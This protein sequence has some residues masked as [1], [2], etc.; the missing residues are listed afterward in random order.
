MDSPDDDN[1]AALA[2][3][4][5]QYT[6]A[7]MEDHR[8][9][10]RQ[11]RAI[12]ATLAIWSDGIRDWVNDGPPRDPLHT[13]PPFDELDLR[14]MTSVNENLAWAAAAADRCEAVADEIATGTLPFD[15][16]GCFF[17]ELLMG[18]AVRSAPELMEQLPELF[19]G[20]PVR[21]AL[22][23]A[24]DD[25]YDGPRLSDDEWDIVSDNFDDVCRWDE[26][27]VPVMNSHPLLAAI[28]AE[29]HPF[30]WFD[31]GPGTRSGYLRRLS[32][33]EN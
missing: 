10:P 19:D 21:P 15:R 7:W 27:E 16:E 31:P 17:D 1:A 5:A 4:A 32:G 13:V 30:R 24:D 6:R 3:E 8:L 12:G 11:A 18:L 29:R 9:T 33:L 25:D 20:I 28:L 14:V 2:E 22:P 26:W 23:E